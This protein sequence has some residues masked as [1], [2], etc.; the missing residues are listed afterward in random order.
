METTAH[1]PTS[2]HGGKEQSIH[3]CVPK[4]QDV[5]TS[6]N[7]WAVEDI[8]ALFALPFP[9]LLFKAQQVHREHFNPNEVEFATLL[10]IKTGGCPE[11]CGY[12]P[13]SV[14]Y[15][16]GVDATKMME[17]DAVREAALAAK[18]A[19]ATRFCMGGLARA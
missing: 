5:P 6:T 7:R 18:E 15:D 9:E 17:A 12:C 8:E 10:S 14:H 2:C 1:N 13:Q 19:G 3:F 11:D 4:K 16:T